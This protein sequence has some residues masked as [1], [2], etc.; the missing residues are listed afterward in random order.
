MGLRSRETYLY[1]NTGVYYE[2]MQALSTLPPDARIL[3]LWEG[4]GLY[5]PGNADP[6]PWLDRWRTDIDQLITAEKVLASWKSS[7][8]TN[9]LLYVDGMRWMRDSDRNL[10]AQ[11]WDAFDLL[12]TRLPQPQSLTGDHYRLYSI[13]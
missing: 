10:S 8:Y 7:G 4:R 2:A 13:P 1:D 6:D 11:E 12:L 9:I 5:A 3:M